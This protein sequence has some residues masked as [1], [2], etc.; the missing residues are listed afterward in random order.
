M[1]LARGY[2]AERLEAAAAR[3]LAAKARSYKHVESILK[4]GLDRLAPRPAT[5]TASTAPPVIHEHLRGKDYY[6]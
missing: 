6:H 4:T 1:R 2:G 3:A 5:P